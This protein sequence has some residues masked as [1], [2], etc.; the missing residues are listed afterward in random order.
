[1]SKQAVNTDQMIRGLDGRSKT[2]IKNTLIQHKMTTAKDRKIK[3]AGTLCLMMEIG[4][5]QK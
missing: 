2:K 3:R 1:M 5:R 4:R